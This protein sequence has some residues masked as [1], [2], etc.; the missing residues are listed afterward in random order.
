MVTVEDLGGAGVA[1][2]LCVLALGSAAMGGSPRAA[3]LGGLL[4]LAA[5]FLVVRA[6]RERSRASEVE[7]S[8]EGSPL[9]RVAR[10]EQLRGLA[11]A[12]GLAWQLIAEPRHAGFCSCNRAPGHCE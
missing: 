8:G 4:A 3:V 11:V 9:V 1:L 12:N 2:L 5:V 10:Y 6:R 7:G